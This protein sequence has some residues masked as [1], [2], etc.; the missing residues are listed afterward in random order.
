M[1]R[2]TAVTLTT[3]ARAVSARTA[4]RAMAASAITFPI[5]TPPKYVVAPSLDP[6]F[7][8]DEFDTPPPAMVP[9]TLHDKAGAP[10]V[11]RKLNLLKCYDI[12]EC[13]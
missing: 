12:L 11:V 6:N 1:L 13:V 3:A 4:V 2:T 7:K 8:N 5:P 9:G 10:G